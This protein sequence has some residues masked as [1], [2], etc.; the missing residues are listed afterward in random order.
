MPDSTDAIRVAVVGATGYAGA[1]LVR[2]LARHPRV[3]LVAVTSEQSAGKRLADVL[4]SVRGKV[5]LE[6]EAF[7]PKT[8]LARCDVAFTALPH[9]ASTAGVAALVEGG[10][11]VV[12]IGSE[13]GIIDK[14]GAWYSYGGQRIGQGRENA[15]MFLKDNPAMMA[16]VEEKVKGVLG[17]KRPEPQVDAEIG[18][19]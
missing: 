2:Y 7:H 13:S 6:L 3:R 10:C 12:D 9:G 8:V 17:L 19:E 16:E 15:K 4:P 11:R 14:S 1:E 5:D 18:E